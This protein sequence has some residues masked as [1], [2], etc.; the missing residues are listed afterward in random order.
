MK[1]V[2]RAKKTAPCTL[3]VAKHPCLEHP[4][5]LIILAGP[6]LRGISLF[7]Q[8]ALYLWAIFLKVWKNS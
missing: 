2:E 4:L 8:P 1:P 7:H 6:A 5:C 3:C